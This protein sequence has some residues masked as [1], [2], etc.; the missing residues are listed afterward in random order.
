[1]RRGSKE[2]VAAGSPVNRASVGKRQLEG[3]ET[4]P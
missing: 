4:D 3:A 1:M 2:G